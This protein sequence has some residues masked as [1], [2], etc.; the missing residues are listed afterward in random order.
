[1]NTLRELR[2]MMTLEL[3]A[4]HS[5]RVAGRELAEDITVVVA[6]LEDEKTD[7]M[8]SACESGGKY[9]GAHSSALSV[10]VI[11]RMLLAKELAQKKQPQG[12]KP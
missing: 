1:M 12:V 5:Q 2:G 6:E 7:A 9:V 3:K 11:K 10:Y 4:E 8:L